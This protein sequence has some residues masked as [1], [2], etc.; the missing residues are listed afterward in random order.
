MVINVLKENRSVF[1]TNHTAFHLAYLHPQIY[2]K[3][4]KD[5]EIRKGNRKYFKKI[6]SQKGQ[7]SK[8]E[9]H[10]LENQIISKVI[11]SG[12]PRLNER[13]KFIDDENNTTWK[14]KGRIWKLK[15]GIW[16]C[17]KGIKESEKNLKIIEIERKKIGRINFHTYISSDE[18]R[19]LVDVSLI[20]GGLNAVGHV[21]VLKKINGEWKITY[22]D[23]TWI[24]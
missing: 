22:F 18:S 20:F 3:N 17:K 19:A 14:L 23:R 16:H 6:M 4:L 8:F 21:Y 2:N 5:L 15:S 12:I 1:L 24:S 9:N 13:K 11:M 7:L 10:N